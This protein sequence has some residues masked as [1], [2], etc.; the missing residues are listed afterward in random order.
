MNRPIIAQFNINSIRNKFQFLEKQA[1][2]NLDILLMSETKLDDLFPS[3]HLLLNGFSKL[4]RLTRCS[5][6]VLVMIVYHAFF[7]IQ[8]KLKI[9]LLRLIS[10][11]RNG[12]SVHPTVLIKVTS[13]TICTIRAK[14]QTIIQEIM[15]IF[16]FQ[17]NLIQ[18][19]QNPV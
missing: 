12:Q 2:G 7:Q 18:N 10:G 4:H 17:E 15:I 3:A 1:C 19:S 5:M 6:V 9:F 11:K 8:I 13:Q 16:F 14:V